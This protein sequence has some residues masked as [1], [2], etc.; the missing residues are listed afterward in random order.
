MQIG[1]S[2]IYSI[3]MDN[4]TLQKLVKLKELKTNLAALIDM[5]EEMPQ[6]DMK[7]VR[8]IEA[9]IRATLGEL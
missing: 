9:N 4:E 8:E 6:P 5:L 2:Q 1:F 3:S 7:E